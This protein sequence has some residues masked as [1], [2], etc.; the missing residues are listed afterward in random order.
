MQQLRIP[1]ELARAAPGGAQVHGERKPM[2]GGAKAEVFPT[3][4]RMRVLVPPYLHPTITA[5]ATP[6][7]W[8]S[9]SILFSSLCARVRPAGMAG[10]LGIWLAILAAIS[11]Y[12]SGELVVWPSTLSELCA[13]LGWKHAYGGWGED[14]IKPLS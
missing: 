11:D 14:A 2:A 10:L 7:L 12:A 4:R 13:R 6:V 1:L 5:P 3:F 8:P 9:P